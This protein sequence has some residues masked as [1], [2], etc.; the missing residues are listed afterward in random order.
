MSYEQ[1]LMQMKKLL[2]KK[3]ADK[4][5]PE[6]KKEIPAPSYEQQWL[7]AGLTKEQNKH[8]IVYKR[9]VEYH[10]DHRHGD[11]VLSG[12]KATVDEWRKSGEPHPLSPDFSKPLL[13]F[14]TETTGLKGAGT[15]IFL[16]GFIEQTA[17]SFKLTQYVLPGPDHEAAFLYASDLWKQ[18]TTLVTYNGKSFDVPQLE[19]RWTMNRNVI[20]PLLTHTQIDLLHGSRRIWKDEMGTFRLPAIEEKQLGF[21]REGDIPGHMA[22]IIYQDAVKNG[23]AELLMKVLDHNEW[24]ILSLVTLYIRS[25]DLLLKTEVSASAVT[26]TNIGKWFADLKSYER[27]KFIFEQSIAEYGVDHPMTHFHLGFI[28]KREQA[29]QEAVQSF[30]IASTGLAGR[31]RII[32]LEELAKLYEHRLKEWGEANRVTKEA[33]WHLQVDPELS[34]RFRIRAS[35]AFA[36]REIRIQRKLFPGEAQE[37]TSGAKS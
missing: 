31:E 9:I 14:D 20:P 24:D 11:I 17:S 30:T 15:L 16:M 32:A 12:L 37:T 34:E 5:V 19:T 21:K 22:P 8:G 27:S 35:T 7:D 23:R 4:V 26:Q 6:V 36:K 25:T 1:K 18:S 33:I 10:S 29:Y 13:F 28:L 3:P 2:K